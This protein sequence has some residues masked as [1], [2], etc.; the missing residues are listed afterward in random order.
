MAITEQ[1]YQE[2]LSRIKED[3]LE[4]SQGVG[5]VPLAEILDG[6]TTLPAYQSSSEQDIEKIVRAPLTLLATPALEASI[7]ANEEEAKRAAAETGRVEAEN[8]RMTEFSKIKADVE[9][10][11]GDANAAADRVDEPIHNAEV[12]TGE[13]QV[14]TASANQAAIS[15]N[16][17][18][19]NAD[20]KAVMAG[21]AAASATDTANH[22]T[23]IGTDHYVYKWNTTTKAYDKMDI[24]C[25][26][27]AF[28]I[29][30]VYVSVAALTADVNNAGIKEGDFVLV[31][32]NNVE[33]PDNAKLYVKAKSDTGVYSYEFLVDMSGAIGFTG[34]TPQFSMGNISTLEAGTTATATVSEDGT[35]S[36]GNPKYKINFAIPRGNP[37]APFRVAG[38]YATLAALQSAVPNGANIDGFMA[39]GTKVPYNYYAWVNGAWKDQ[40]QIVGGGG[41]IVNI[42]SAILNLTGS[43]TSA[44]ILNVFG[45]LSKLQEL[46]VKLRSQ[47][48]IIMV[49]DN[50]G[51]YIFTFDDY[52]I[53][54]TDA[55]N[56][57]LHLFDVFNDAY[58]KAYRRYIKVSVTNDMA[59]LVATK[60]AILSS[61]EIAND[62]ITDS[63]TDVLSAAMGKKLQDNKA[64]KSDV[65]TKT[66]NTVYTPTGDYNPA[67]K[68]YVDDT[69]KNIQV[70]I[71]NQSAK[72]RL[73]ANATITSQATV[74][75]YINSIFGTIDNFKSIVYDINVNSKDLEFD[76]SLGDS[77][78]FIIRASSISTVCNNG[79][80]E[81]RLTFSLTRFL[82]LNT[83]ED[84]IITIYYSNGEKLFTVSNRVVSNNINTVT[85][86]TQAEY[87][88]ITTKD[89]STMY[90]IIN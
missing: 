88:A 47:N 90:A 32:T 50:N 80:T 59:G 16:Q 66:N 25:K 48:C 14:A 56:F 17:S 44:E 7:K 37:G 89:N 67:T 52:T 10:A 45:G 2:L 71:P 72:N 57:V 3:L 1:E 85:K 22:P 36:N 73:F 87:D 64:E 27:D 70:I 11:T 12:A 19:D 75:D 42:S 9:K 46:V 38:E 43:S 6:I 30:K 55:R 18:A 74:T 77:S 54:Y 29:K 86:K 31:N 65:L 34:K 79:K 13:A 33:N 78:K 24:Y 82:D 23:Y 81:V 20:E 15:A 35:D 61:S 76:L 63:A 21:T 40:G 51:S 53:G 28:S 83:V 60:I 69:Y 26:G 49:G 68:K 41:N 4:S 62:L 5:E 8:T 58:G 84:K 39:V